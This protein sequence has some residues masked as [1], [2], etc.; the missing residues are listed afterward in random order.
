LTPLTIE[1]RIFIGQL[2]CV[3]SGTV[4]VRHISNSC[5]YFDTTVRQIMPGVKVNVC[6]LN[7][8]YI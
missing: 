6:S 8:A 7:T 5:R 1:T 3:R 4:P 2:K